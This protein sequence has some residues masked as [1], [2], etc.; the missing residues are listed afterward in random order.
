MKSLPVKFLSITIFLFLWMVTFMIVYHGPLVEISKGENMFV[1]SLVNLN[2]LK[3]PIIWPDA[4]ICKSPFER[5][6]EK[7]FEYVSKAKNY[8][9][10][11][12]T[13]YQRFIEES[14]FT[15]PEDFVHAIGFSSRFEQMY[16][17]SHRVSPKPP[18]VTSMFQ[19]VFYFGYCAT[20]HFE[21]LRLKLIADGELNG[22][23]IDSSF[24]AVIG[25]EVQCSFSR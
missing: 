10:I 1:K 2:D 25:L 16:D 11:N 18:Y 13:E 22:N 7:Y 6:K 23:E 21:E 8:S 12:E 19:D 9:F 3:K 24:S 15:K 4:N 14:F 17:I 5:N 20:I